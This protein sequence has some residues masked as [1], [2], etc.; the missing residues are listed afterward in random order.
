MPGIRHTPATHCQHAIAANAS[1]ARSSASTRAALEKVLH[2]LLGQP[3]ELLRISAPALLYTVQN[4]AL[5]IGLANLEAAVAQV[6]YQSKIFTT[7]LFSVCLLGQRLRRSQ[8][9]ALA[10]LAF[11]VLC[12]QGLPERLVSH[13][14][15]ERLG[16]S[17]TSSTGSAAAGEAPSPL[18]PQPHSQHRR[19]ASGRAAFGAAASTGAAA[20]VG[21]DAAAARAAVVGM[22]AMLV[23]CL[24]SSFAAGACRGYDHGR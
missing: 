11:G 24:C 10:L 21:V 7:A 2:T 16:A 17:A 4:N 14:L 12:V 3:A 5:F 15:T 8:W 18:Q 20:A 22:C 9:L 19:R 23:A 6:T 13:L 1:L